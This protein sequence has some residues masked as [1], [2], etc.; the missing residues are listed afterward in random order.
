LTIILHGL[1]LVNEIRAKVHAVGHLAALTIRSGSN[2]FG[3]AGS[4][5]DGNAQET[6]GDQMGRRDRW[7]KCLPRGSVP[8]KSACSKRLAP[9]GFSDFPVLTGW[10]R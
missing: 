2:R 4:E 1:H 6:R 3:E 5:T 9:N 10:M 8:A 7:P